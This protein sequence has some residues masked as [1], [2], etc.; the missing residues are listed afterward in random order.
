MNA[1]A[2]NN[3]ADRLNRMVKLAMDTGEAASVEDAERLFAGYRLAV[4]AGADVGRSPTLQ[5][6]LLTIVNA[7]RRCL[8]GGIEVAGIADMTLLVP[9]P[10]FETLEQAVTGLGGRVVDAVSPDAPLVVLGDVEEWS[11]HPFAVRATFD[12]WAGGIVPLGQSAMR[13]GER[14]E[15]TLAG[16]LAGALA[17]TE[18]FQFLRGN[19]PAAG[20]REAG[21]S[22]WRPELH[23]QDSAASGPVIDR[24][25]AALWLIGLG[26]LGQ[27]YLWT[28]GLLPYAAPGDVQLVL[29][30]FDVLAPSNES[31]SLLTGRSLVGRRKTRAMADWAERRGFRTAI[32]ERPFG[33]NVK[34]RNDEP[35]LALCGVDNALA[36]SALEDVGFGRV[37]EA[38][39]GGGPSDFLGFRTHG[40]PGVRK[41]RDVW[42]PCSESF[43]QRVDLPAYRTL[44]AAGLDRC[45]LVQLAGRTVGA[46]FVGAVAAAAVVG[47]AL[48][49]VN[50]AHCYDLIDGHLRDLAHRTAV[51]A[52][53]R[54]PFNPGSTVAGD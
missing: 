21:L 31:T 19:Q 34:I 30:D 40:F 23:W 51:P 7:G 44:A 4:A 47:E 54:A 28:L 35:P 52:Q 25:P 32:I 15:F 38:G 1:I 39:L 41:A 36:R 2:H 6:A 5:A 14:H 3:I 53:D 24:L 49:V 45:G 29:Q 17:V 48:R 33:P 26:N 13:M 46:P 50:G 20:R 11:G 16:V 18:A 9:V 10:P 22:L 12:G 43:E 42:N 27:A 37:I 8:L